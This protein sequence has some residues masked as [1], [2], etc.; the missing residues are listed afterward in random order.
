[1]TDSEKICLQIEN[2]ILLSEFFQ[3]VKNIANVA[4]LL[5]TVEAINRNGESKRLTVQLFNRSSTNR[6]CIT[7]P[8]NL[9][10]HK[11]R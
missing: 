10:E 11:T 2:S 4:S 3:E 1:M 7:S 5:Q 8:S 9:F 6:T